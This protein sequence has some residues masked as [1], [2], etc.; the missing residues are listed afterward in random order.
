MS[1]N[2]SGLEKIVPI[3]AAAKFARKSQ[4][5]NIAKTIC[6][7]KRGE[8]AKKIPMAKPNATLCGVADIRK[9]RLR[10]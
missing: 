5:K 1:K 7:P 8:Q 6:M 9:I 4:D 2:V 10:M 3:I